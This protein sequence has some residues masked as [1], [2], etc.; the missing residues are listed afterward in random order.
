[1]FIIGLKTLREKLGIDVMAELKAS[2]MEARGRQDAAGMEL[3][4]LGVSEPNAGAVLRAAIAVMTFGPGGDAP[5]N[6]DDGVTLTLLSQLTM[7]FHDSDVEMQDLVGA[8]ET[9]VDDAVDRGSPP[10]YT[11]LLRGIAF[12]THLDVCSWA[13]NGQPTCT[14]ES[15]GGAASARG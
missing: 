13:L 14:C 11:K 1:M 7:M 15:H 5:G 9:V 10:E 4:A 8:L 2:L 6:M 3:N 12:R